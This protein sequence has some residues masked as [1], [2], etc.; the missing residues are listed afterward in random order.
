MSGLGK[1][2]AGGSEG[3]GEGGP[4]EMDLSKMCPAL[5][6]LTTCLDGAKCTMKDMLSKLTGMME[7]MGGGEEGGEGGQG[8]QGGELEKGPDKEGMGMMVEQL[9]AVCKGGCDMEKF[10]KCR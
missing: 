1:S 9:F 2:M 4:G 6:A 5:N 3:G 7:N 10:K 8:G